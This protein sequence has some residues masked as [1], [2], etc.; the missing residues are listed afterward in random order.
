VNSFLT[1]LGDGDLDAVPAMFVPNA[2]IGTASLRDGKW[3]ASTTTFEQ[4]FDSLKARTSWSR[5]REPVSKFDVFIEDGQMAFVRADATIVT[6]DVA[7][8]HNIDYFTLVRQD[9]SWK[10]L[11]ASYV[12]KPIVSE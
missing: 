6:D 10:F 5:F 9:G 11:S 1:A 7:R 4:W 2:N 8:S 3:I 12:A